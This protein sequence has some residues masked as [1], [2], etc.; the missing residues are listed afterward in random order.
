M[1]SSEKSNGYVNA[2]QWHDTRVHALVTAA[3]DAQVESEFKK[4]LNGH[5]DENGFAQHRGE[6]MPKAVALQKE[7]EYQAELERQRM[8]SAAEAERQARL[9]AEREQREREAR[10]RAE[11]EQRARK[12]KLAQLAR[13]SAGVDIPKVINGVLGEQAKGNVGAEYWEDGSTMDRLFA[14]TAWTIVDTELAG[15]I[16]EVTVRV[17]SS[18]KGGAQIRALWLF[19][20]RYG[21]AGWKVALLLE[22]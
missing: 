22:K 5:M 20:L 10:A 3:R 19:V 13:A 21:E 14:P 16:A 18:N 9:A 8:E 12:E 1:R 6:W 15:N 11:A 2:F 7:Q 4:G 17:D